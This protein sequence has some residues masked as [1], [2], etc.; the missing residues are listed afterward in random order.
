[1]TVVVCGLGQ[2][3]RGDDAAGLEA[4]HLWQSRFPTQAQHPNVQVQMLEVPN[5]AL[6]DIL[7]GTNAALLV[8][9]AQAQAPPGSIH[10]L[11]ADALPPFVAG[12]SS[13]H[14]WS[15]AETLALARALGRPL[16]PRLDILAI[17]AADFTIG[18]GLSPTVRA[19]L[20]QAAEAIA[21]WVAQR[22]LER[23][24]A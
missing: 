19:A 18:A 14:G 8:D 16:P 2:P 13:A 4:V 7:E 20:P 23:T 17:V 1:M 12:T 3:L 9:A 24:P 15:P 10:C 11:T 22:L 6:L 21:Q 5:I